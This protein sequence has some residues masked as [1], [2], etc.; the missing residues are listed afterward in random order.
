MSIPVPDFV[1]RVVRDGEDP[2][3]EADHGDA[4]EVHLDE[5][6]PR[7]GRV[8]GVGYVLAD[9]VRSGLTLYTPGPLPLLGADPVSV[10][11]SEAGLPADETP[12]AVPLPKGSLAGA[13]LPYD[14]I[15]FA[16]RPEHCT[17]VFRALDRMVLA[18]RD[19]FPWQSVHQTGAIADPL[20]PPGV[21]PEILPV[22]AYGIKSVREA[23]LWK[24]TFGRGRRPTLTLTRVS[25]PPPDLVSRPR[26]PRL[27][28]PS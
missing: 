28:S 20:V 5:V 24:Q 6:G 7:P 25:P 23:Y 19:G 27:S 11:W 9:L 18:P 13:P 3:P 15:V 14:R 10:A 21:R 12:Y 17:V 2:L 22:H 26:V 16:V 4:P 1:S 8:F